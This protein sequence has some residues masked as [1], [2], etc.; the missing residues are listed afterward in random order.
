[1]VGPQ[2]G[3]RNLDSAET[4]PSKS[5]LKFCQRMSDRLLRAGS[6]LPDSV[7]L[8]VLGAFSWSSIFVFFF[9][10]WFVLQTSPWRNLNSEVSSLLV[11]LSPSPCNWT[12]FQGKA[13]SLLSCSGSQQPGR[14]TSCVSHH[15][16]T[17]CILTH[18]EAG[19]PLTHQ[20]PS[21]TLVHK[22][23][24]QQRGV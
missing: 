19:I 14:L 15:L 17:T 13:C 24:G 9:C 20:F 12:A 5:E 21:P 22:P 10:M 7:R 23:L 2:Q 11:S 6:W 16:H 18:M 3:N 1:M 8:L 4:A